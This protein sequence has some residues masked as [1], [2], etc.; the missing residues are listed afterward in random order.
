MSTM[1]IQGLIKIVR[2]KD[3]LFSHSFH[4]C[5]Q[6]FLWYMQMYQ[7][8][9][10]RFMFLYRQKIKLNLCNNIVASIMLWALSWF[11]VTSVSRIL[12]LKAALKY[13]I[14]IK[15]WISTLPTSLT[16]LYFGDPS[17]GSE[18]LSITGCMFLFA[19]CTMLSIILSV[20]KFDSRRWVFHILSSTW[21]TRL[22]RT[23]FQLLFYGFVRLYLFSIPFLPFSWSQ[24]I[25]NYAQLVVVR[26]YNCHHLEHHQGFWSFVSVK[27]LQ[28]FQ[29][30]L[31][32]SLWKY[33]PYQHLLLQFIFLLS[34][35]S[36]IQFLVW[37]RPHQLHFL[38]HR[39]HSHS[40]VQSHHLY[41]LHYELISKEI[42]FSFIYYQ[43]HNILRLFD[44]LPTSKVNCG[45]KV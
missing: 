10:G 6:I 34:S 30:H 3:A 27:L 36:F 31:M 35:S 25:Q 5:P 19:Y 16:W 45:D 18:N 11:Q 44:V 26:Y 24:H 33:F 2:E 12:N 39:Y 23:H 32:F 42:F 38:P 15:A 7:S 29:I 20:K 4:S 17:I 43:F 28:S 22:F 9:N 13:K 1:W 21:R 37:P 41:Y 8:S 40:P 14:P